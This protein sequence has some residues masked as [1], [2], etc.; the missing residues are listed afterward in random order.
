[1]MQ[2]LDGILYDLDG[3]LLN[4]FPEYPARVLRQTLE[5]LH[6]EVSDNFVY[7][8]WND[9]DREKMIVRETGVNFDDFWKTFW[10]YDTPEA[11]RNNISICDDAQALETLRQ[12]TSGKIKFGIVT[13]SLKEVAYAE[14]EVL[15]KRIP[16]VEFGSVVTNLYGTGYPD[17]PD[18]FPLELC[19]SELG[20]RKDRAMY[21]GDNEEDKELIRRSG[22]RGL[23]IDR[24]LKE[25]P[26]LSDT[27]EIKKIRTL[28]EIEEL[29]GF[30]EAISHLG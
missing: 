29:P 6:C 1:M 22:I 16:R 5:E 13:K 28:Y 21:V 4:V 17:K 8:F 12:L 2:R 26:D 3:T 9:P 10:K 14:V 20:V 11:R 18:P 24:G 23:I 7:R 15:R 30:F 27:P 19:L 25:S